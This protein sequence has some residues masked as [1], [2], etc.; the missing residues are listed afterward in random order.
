MESICRFDSCYF[1]QNRFPGHNLCDID[2]IAFVV[3]P[4]TAVIAFIAAVIIMKLAKIYRYRLQ[5]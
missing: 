3:S 4:V 2:S 5:L 1:H